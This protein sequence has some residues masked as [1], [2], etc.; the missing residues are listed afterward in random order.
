M[1]PVSE[2]GS[3]S[4]ERILGALQYLTKPEKRDLAQALEAE[5]HNELDARCAEIKVEQH[6]PNL[7]ADPSSGCLF[8]LQNLTLTEDEHWLAKRTAPKAPFPRKTYFNHVLGA[9]QRPL[10]EHS[11]HCQQLYIPKSRE[12]MTSYL[13]MGYVAWLCQWHPN[14]FVVLQSQ[15]DAKAED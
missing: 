10:V 9:M 13:A 15:Q 11:I 3:Y 1:I 4:K 12:M 6:G 7:V 5:W 14:I 8:W 2:F